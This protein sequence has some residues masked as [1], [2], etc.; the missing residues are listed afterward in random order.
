MF[1]IG[2]CP[3]FE[4]TLEEDNFLRQETVL[5]AAEQLELAVTCLEAKVTLMSI[6]RGWNATISQMTGRLN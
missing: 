5:Y 6:E 4:D 1:F 3:D 2:M